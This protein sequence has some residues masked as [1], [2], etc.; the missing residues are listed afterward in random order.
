MAK[1]HVSTL[2]LSTRIEIVAE[3]LLPQEKREWGRISEMAETAGLSRTRLYQLKE[4]AESFL[5]KILAPENPGRPK[6]NEHLVVDEEMIKRAIAIFPLIK[7]STRD[8]QMGLEMLFGVQRSVGYINQTLHE[9]GEQARQYNE[10]M[11]T[12]K[13]ILAEVDEIFQG[14]KP[15]LTVVDGDSFLLLNLNPTQSR[16]ET[17]WGV[18]LLELEEQGYEFADVVA[19]GAD[20][21]G[22][23]L[24][25]A[26]T[27][28]AW[29][30]FP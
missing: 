26:R 7:G 22:F 29:L 8:I 17:S 5:Q 28:H 25:T 18:T 11:V 27:A 14:R 24:G 9:A 15:C 4:K 6:P 21:C 19:D 3:M 13:P 23:L 10:G 20:A 2:D 12:S 16:D 30:W 1:Y